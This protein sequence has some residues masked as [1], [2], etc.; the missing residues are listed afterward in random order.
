MTNAPSTPLITRSIV[1][2]SFQSPSTSSTPC[3]AQLDAFSRLR[4]SARTSLPCANRCSAV[5]PPTLPVIPITKNICVLLILRDRARQARADQSALERAQ[6]HDPG[7][8]RRA[9][10]R[11]WASRLRPGTERCSK[12]IAAL[13]FEEL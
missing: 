8:G 7:E 3:F 12:R 9:Q 1:A 2:E 6:V 5:A 13:P 4:T 10:S 11:S